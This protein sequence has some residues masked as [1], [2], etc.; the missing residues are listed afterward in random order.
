MEEQNRPRTVSLFSSPRI[1][2][3]RL[4]LKYMA[5][6]QKLGDSA[7]ISVRELIY[8]CSVSPELKVPAALNSKEAKYLQFQEVSSFNKKFTLR[9]FFN[10]CFK[11]CN[12][13][14]SL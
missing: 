8:I 2:I 13:K 3:C 12:E 9:K 6:L 5:Y 1:N 4:E 10:N 14:L 7:E 11:Y